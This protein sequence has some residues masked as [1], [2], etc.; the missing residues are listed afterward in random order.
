MVIAKERFRAAGIHLGISVCI[1]ALAALLVFAI[2]YPYP[3]REVSGGRDL[4]L[5]VITVDVILGPLITLTVF[6]RKK[7]RRELAVD[8]T[9]V[10]CV[11]IAALAYGLWTVAV[12]RPV[13]LVFEFD[14]LRV[15]HAVDIPEEL[16]PLVPAGIDAEPWHGPTLL[17]VRPFRNPQEKVDVTLQALQG[18]Q[19]AARPDLWQTYDAARPRILQ[20]AQPVEAL[21]RK[22]PSEAGRIDAAL[23]R[24]GR[25]APHTSYLPMISRKIA[26]TAF[27]DPQTADVVGFAPLDSF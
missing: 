4:F 11:Q 15:V 9:F 14:R 13:H 25:D 22:L 5:I 16:L 20:A 7:S 2:W 21:K 19:A 12:A 26:W 3:Y 1:A 17:A 6:N 10:A 23:R 18:V 8:L 27:I 24:I